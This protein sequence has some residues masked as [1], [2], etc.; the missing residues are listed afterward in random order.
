LTWRLAGGFAFVSVYAFEPGGRRVLAV[1]PTG[2]GS[3]AQPVLVLRASVPESQAGELCAA[4]TALSQAVWATYALPASAAVDDDELS[5]REQ[6]RESRDLVLEALGAPNL[7][8]DFGMLVVPY[9]AVEESAHRLGRLL[10]DFGDLALTE[11][12]VAE[13]AVEITAVTSAELGDLSGRAGQATA[14][15][16]LD[17]SRL[18]VAAADDLLRADP[19]GSD[20]LTALVDPAAACL[21]AAYWLAAAAV[22]AAGIADLDAADV[23]AEADNIEAVSVAVPTEVVA[24]IV[25]DETD[26]RVVVLDCCVLRSRRVTASS[27]TCPE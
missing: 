9:I 13:V 2:V 6:E 17:V 7:P 20:L 18:Q 11:A 3:L 26:A 22:V 5:R 1:W 10:H 12:V 4:L 19:L 24:R 27:L 25:D 14:L 23:F 15:D 8:D 21:A 16:R